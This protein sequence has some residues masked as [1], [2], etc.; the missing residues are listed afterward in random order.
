MIKND[1]PI[2]PLSSI[3][4]PGGYMPLRIFEPRYLDMVKNCV[5]NNTGFGI[6]LTKIDRNQFYEVGTYCKIT[7]WEQ[8]GLE[9]YILR[10]VKRQGNQLVDLRLVV[11]D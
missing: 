11:V 6:S 8:N 10:A 7:D 9:E 1:V 3:T 4:F 5:K 2:F